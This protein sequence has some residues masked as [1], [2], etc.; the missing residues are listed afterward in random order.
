MSSASLILLVIFVGWV[1][2]D[3]LAKCTKGCKDGFITIDGQKKSCQPCGK[4]GS[5]EVGGN[6]E[7]CTKDCPEDGLIIID[8]VKQICKPC[9]EPGSIQVADGDPHFSVNLKNSNLNR[10]VCF[11]MAGSP[12]QVYRLY[13]VDGRFTVDG[14]YVASPRFNRPGAKYFGRFVFRTANV[15]VAI[16]PT[17]V[18]ITAADGQKQIKPWHP[19]VSHVHPIFYSD[20]ALEIV[21]W[22]RKVI[23]VNFEGTQFQIKRNLLKYGADKRDFFYLGIYMEKASDSA[24]YGGIFGDALSKQAT[25]AKSESGVDV[26]II[27]DSSGSSRTVFVTDERRF[28]YIR[29]KSFGCWLVTD[30]DVLLNRPF[31]SY[32]I[33]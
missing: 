14:Q 22:Q 2:G 4:V 32:R 9:R 29:S 17:S 25:H 26:L 8:G 27:K 1:N 18:T 28:D 21:H 24:F 5:I 20:D 6:L 3:E 31:G 19:W 13:E 16:E 23:R 33:R 12:G 30:V 11:N 10:P 15:T 7:K